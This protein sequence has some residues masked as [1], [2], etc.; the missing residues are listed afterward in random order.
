MGECHAA[1]LVPLLALGEH[2]T[3]IIAGGGG[4]I[5]KGD[6]SQKPY[7]F[8]SKLVTAAFGWF[9]CVQM[10]PR[11]RFLVGISTNDL[12]EGMGFLRKV[13]AAASSDDPLDVD[14]HA[15]EVD[16]DAV[17]FL[18][19]ERAL[20]DAAARGDHAAVR[21]LFEA[22]PAHPSSGGT[23]VGVDV[24]WHDRSGNTALMLAAQG[25]HLAVVKEL[26]RRG[27]DPGL[28][29][30]AGHTAAGIAPSG[31]V[32]DFVMETQQ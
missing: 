26:V 23:D 4:G 29:N 22:P 28:K 7:H 9:D 14:G 31:A 11:L 21:D 5:K 10:L 12:K 16:Q 17:A 19:A 20:L 30:R 1:A 2:L 6:F 25:G 8:Q 3:A 15:Y 24:D 27:A 18:Q 13:L 32:R